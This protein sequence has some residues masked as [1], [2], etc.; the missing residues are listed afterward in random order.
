M[1]NNEVEGHW[2]V[3]SYE[4][5]HLKE[6]GGSDGKESACSVGNLGS[7]PGSGRSPGEGNGSTLQYSCLE[8]PKDKGGWRATE[9]G[10]G[11][12]RTHVSSWDF[13]FQLCKHAFKDERLY[14][15]AFKDEYISVYQNKDDKQRSSWSS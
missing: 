15:C 1:V 10:V 11:K 7:V 2:K 3:S 14:R 5:V 13:H 6:K 12:S 4:G 8:N 9:C